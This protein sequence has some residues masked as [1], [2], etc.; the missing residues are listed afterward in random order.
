MLCPVAACRSC[1]PSLSLP[2]F[3]T[4]P[5]L[6][7]RVGQ[8]WSAVDPGLGPAA[9]IS[10]SMGGLFSGPASSSV[11]W[12]I[13]F[14][15]VEEGWWSQYS[16]QQVPLS[17]PL[18]EDSALEFSVRNQLSSPRKGRAWLS[19]RHPFPPLGGRE[20]KG[21]AWNRHRLGLVTSGTQFSYAKA[22]FLGCTRTLV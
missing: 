1:G 19:D 18:A 16:G 15:P 14:S 17:F 5:A 12:Q 4:I 10:G 2:W 22:C 3:L 8:L 9:P 20:N 21:V 13:S 7:F 11:Q 6:T